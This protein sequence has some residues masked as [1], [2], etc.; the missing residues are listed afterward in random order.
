[1]PDFINKKDLWEKAVKL[2]EEAFRQVQK[3]RAN[4]DPAS[5]EQW[6]HWAAVLTERTAFKHD[7]VNHP[8]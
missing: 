4:D 8:A 2:E 3:Y 6:K 1:M 5:F 7:V